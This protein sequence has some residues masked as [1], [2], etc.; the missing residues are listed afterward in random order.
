[1][2]NRKLHRILKFILIAITTAFFTYGLLW[3][4]NNGYL[5]EE[6]YG[7]TVEKAWRYLTK[8]ALQESGKVGYVQPIGENAAQHQVDAETTADFGVGAFLL[9]ACEMARY[10]DIEKNEIELRIP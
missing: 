10:V 1:M 9:A 4:I 2:L 8:I 6:R 7:K 5:S 3:G